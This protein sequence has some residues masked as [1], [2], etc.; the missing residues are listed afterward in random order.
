MK[1]KK[2]NEIISEN[3]KLEKELKKNNIPSY[4]IGILSNIMIHQSKDIGE[5]LL[6][7]QEILAEIKFGAIRLLL[8][9]LKTIEPFLPNFTAPH[10]TIFI[11]LFIVSSIF[12]DLKRIDISG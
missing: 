8:E 6:R 12:V 2:F 5:Y 3:K 4:K 9:L 11:N 1:N 7:K 10:L